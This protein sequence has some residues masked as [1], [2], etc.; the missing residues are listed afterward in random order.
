MGV[1]A[2]KSSEPAG[3]SARVENVLSRCLS[4][5]K[6]LPGSLAGFCLL[7]WVLSGVEQLG[8]FSEAPLPGGILQSGSCM[9]LL[10]CYN[11]VW[12]SDLEDFSCWLLESEL[13]LLTGVLVNLVP[14][15]E[16]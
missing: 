12:S 2:R 9:M 6:P 16:N 1:R 4:W 3:S 5:S 13:L 14:S 15:L 7:L 10:C 8:G 11:G